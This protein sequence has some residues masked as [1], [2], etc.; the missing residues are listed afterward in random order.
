MDFLAK[1]QTKEPVS[2]AKSNGLVWCVL[3]VD[4]DP[5]VHAVTR[6]ALR[7][8]QF[9]DRD[10]DIISA[11]SGN[12]A[13]LIFEQRK[14]IS[15]ALVDV[16]M[17]TEHAGLDLVK[18]LRVEKGNH[19]VRLVLRTGQAGQAPEDQVIR[20][21][22]IDDYRE[23]TD[24]TKQK[25]RTLLYSML[26]S[27]RD[28]DVIE[29]QRDGLEN[30]IES[31]AKIQDASSFKNFALA[32]LE[33][34]VILHHFGDSEIYYIEVPSKDRIVQ[35]TRILITTTET[36]N[37]EKDGSFDML[38]PKVAQRFDE[39]HSMKTSKSYSDAYV[40]YSPAAGGGSN[41]VYISHH[42]ALSTLDQQLLEI[43]VQNLAITFGNINLQDDLQDASKELIFTLTDTVEARSNETGAHIQRVAL[44]S[45]RLAQLSG[46]SDYETTLIKLASPLHDIGKIAIP[47]AILHK[48]GKLDPDEWEIMKKHVDY[49]VAILERSKSELMI[50]ATQ[51]AGTHHE[52]WDGT[53]YPKML[54]GQEIPIAGRITTL[55]DVFDGLG[56]KRSYKEAWSPEEVLNFILAERGKLFDP[57]LVDLFVAHYDEFI[58]IRK[59]HPDTYPDKH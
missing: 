21:Y 3:I 4:D 27:Y 25:L 26:R 41:L 29:A 33:Q 39:V 49:G 11:Y 54:K 12:E 51:I 59:Q 31:C 53:G 46:L 30:V 47:D 28:I 7:N 38:P 40:F 18:H 8:F 48:P 44:I 9:E 50:I 24:L 35:K 23:K 55:A 6:L 43:Y 32:A 1:K 19:K 10:I 56:S 34:M 57:S 17:E 22:D 37:F 20:E 15:L 14:D 36:I 16:V 42:V 58:E 2:H 52:R 13:K 45:E 5:E